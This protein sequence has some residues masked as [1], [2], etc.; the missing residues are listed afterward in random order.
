MKRSKAKCAVLTLALLLATVQVGN[1]S[2]KIAGIKVYTPPTGSDLYT[3]P[4][5][6]GVDPNGNTSKV[7]A[8]TPT[9][10]AAEV[11]QTLVKELVEIVNSTDS[12][13]TFVLTVA[14]LEQLGDRAKSSVPTIIRNAERLKIFS[15]TTTYNPNAVPG[16]KQQLANA[17]AQSIASLLG[18]NRP[19]TPVR[20]PSCY[21][22]PAAY[23]V[24][25]AP[26]C[27]PSPPAVPLM[28]MYQA[29]R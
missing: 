3:Y 12:T 10:T 20:A 24:P 14:A 28:P 11:D 27:C 25:P 17:V 16:K 2:G 19:V 15:G 22:T 8:V 6:T 9:P 29:P 1:A 26:P 13:T 4:P 21:A 23:N 18:G 7:K 5:Y